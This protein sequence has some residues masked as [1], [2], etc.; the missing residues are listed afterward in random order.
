VFIQIHAGVGS[1]ARGKQGSVELLSRLLVLQ[2][3]PRDLAEHPR[4]ARVE[5]LQLRMLIDEVPGAADVPDGLVQK[6]GGAVAETLA[7]LDPL[8]DIESVRK[9][10]CLEVP[11]HHGQHGIVPA[12]CRHHSSPEIASSKI[13]KKQKDE[14]IS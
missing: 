10:V 3:V 14:A 12:E 1:Q 4:G 6:V 8:L 13:I 5:R 9:Q 2:R 7:A 11:E